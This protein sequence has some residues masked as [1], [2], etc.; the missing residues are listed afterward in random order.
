MSS[1]PR[2]QGARDRFINGWD[3]NLAVV[4]NAGSGKTTAVSRRLAAMALSK[5]GPAMLAR[6]AVVTYTK[7]AAAQIEQSARAEM[8]RRLAESM[9]G[10]MGALTGLDRVFF[11]TIHSFCL[12]L[13]RRHGSPL[14]VHLNPT[15]VEEDDGASWQEFL[16]QDPM[17]FASLSDAQV[18]A[19]LRHSPLDDIFGLAASLNH[20]NARRLIA[21]KPSARPPSPSQAVLDE[22]LATVPA[23]KGAATRALHANKD[24]ARA[25]MKQF[26]EERG[27]LPIAEPEGKA[28]TIVDLYRRFFAPLK[29]W[30]A[31]AGGVMAAELSLRYRAWRADRGVQTYADQVETA[32]AVLAD[33]SLLEKIRAEGWRVILD[34]AQDTDREQFDVLTEIAR[35]P[36][37]AR[38]TWPDGG[39][40]PPRP[41]HLCMVGDA[42][43]GIYSE[44][45]DIANFQRHVDAFGRGDGGEK[46]TFDVTFRA[47]RRL[48][49]LLNATLPAAF[50]DGRLHNLGLPAFEGA[51]AKLLQVAY[52]PLVAGPSNIGGGAWRLPLETAVVAGAKKVSDRA[53]KD[54]LRQLARF[55]ASGG[56]GSVGASCWGDVCILAPRKAWLALVREALDEVGLKS[57]V[58]I[59]RNRNGDNPVYAWL[60]GLLAVVCDPNNAFEWVGVLRE[61]FAVSDAVIAGAVLGSGLRYDE[62]GDAPVPVAAALGLL[63]PY[64]EQADQEGV[65]LL[66]FATGLVEAC[67]LDRK[68]AL[69][70]P[71]GG[72][73]DELAR[74]IARAAELGNAGGGPRDWLRDLLASIDAH[75]SAGRPLS[76]SVNV[77]TSHSSKG[78]EWPVVI[79]VGVWRAIESPPQR[80]LRLVRDRP[81]EMQVVFDNDGVEPDTKESMDRAE[82]RILVRLLYV[83]LT[84]PRAALIV[85]WS[86]RA[87]E[88]NSF[89]E[90]WGIEPGALEPLPLAEASP[91]PARVAEAVPVAEQLLASGVPATPFPERV[92]PHT[93]A[94]APDAARAAL[95]ES[96][97]DLPGPTRDGPDPLE[98]GVWWHETLEFVPWMGDEASVAA[99]GATSLARATDMGFGTRGEEEWGRLLASEGWKSLRDPRWTRLAEVGIFAPLSEGR[100]IDGVIDL[101]LHDPAFNEL[102]IVDWKTNR[103]QAGEADPCLLS[104]LAEEYQRQLSAY[105][106]CAGRFFPGC[107]MSLWVYSTVAG[108]L[109]EVIPE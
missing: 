54:E 39:G 35:P 98:F 18:D 50:G 17:T 37:A 5:E 26:E 69:L 34:E 103:R 89:A 55:L 3:S 25:W 61:V 4:A 94:K 8:L 60:C 44:R 91:G 100:W 30:L 23:R 106:T 76:D 16:E 79:P 20:A 45:A 11:G 75:R 101:I 68:A 52:E 41:G 107:R 24:T 74:L 109:V 51:E 59:R 48:V 31:A 66:A 97:L 64:I 81:G 6:T 63:A 28:G 49:S 19:F 13:A 47:P 43:Q 70:D 21:A 104:R 96:S 88:D 53:L 93:L 86:G 95:H 12:V 77:M 102:W 56:P 72:L 14:G 27:R 15:V 80:G 42:Q 40:P 73:T 90:L 57:S 71:D 36:G 62:P 82:S 78:L 46:L 1:L 83:T 85:P 33:A 108:L 22:I 7:K 84:R 92:L 38:G 9:E 2:D 65:S 87:A 10:G 29:Q 67:G 99:H 32:L 105:G 58:Q